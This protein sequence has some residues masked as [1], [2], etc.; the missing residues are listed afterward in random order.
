MIVLFLDSAP[1][2]S[3][4]KKLFLN[5]L[6]KSSADLEGKNSTGNNDNLIR[7]LKLYIFSQMV[8]F[9]D[10][11]DEWNSVWFTL[12]YTNQIIYAEGVAAE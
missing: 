7:K 6:F 11:N 3:I 5:F 1:N 4:Q 9:L 10:R 2:C 12:S 8:K